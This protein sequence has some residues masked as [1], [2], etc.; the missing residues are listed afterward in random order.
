MK[1]YRFTF[2]VPAGKLQTITG[3]IDGEVEELK[4][5]SVEMLQGKIMKRAILPD[6]VHARRNMYPGGS[7]KL[8]LDN[9]VPAMVYTQDFMHGLMLKHGYAEGTCSP[10]MSNLV[11][12]GRFELLERGKWKRLT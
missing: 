5:E 4:I 9:T 6:R 1:G 2:T 7:A 11:K 12:Q 8:I 3:A 10:E